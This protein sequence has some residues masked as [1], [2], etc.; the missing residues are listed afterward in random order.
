[1]SSGN[2]DKKSKKLL[3]MM[4]FALLLLNAGLFY[5]IFANKQEAEK[6]KVELV[7]T[8]AEVAELEYLTE[9]LRV[10]LEAKTGKNAQLDSIIRVRDTELQS[11]VRKVRN[12]LSRSNL[13]KSE[14]AKAKEELSGLRGQIEQLTAEIEQ[15]SK[16]NQFLKDENYAIQIQV[17]AEKEKVAEMVVVN[18]D[19]TKQVA[20]GSRIF[21][22]SLDVK[23]LRDVFFGDYKTTDKISK[24]DKIDVSFQL[25]NNDLAEKGSKII[26]FQVI[27]PTKSVLTNSNA[28]SGLAS[29]NGGEKQYTVKKSINFQNKNESGSFSIP[30]TEGMT[31]GQY[32]VN[33]FSDEHKMGSAEFT[34]K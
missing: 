28:G 8:Q 15:L 31:A 27:K 7:D 25:A 12:M 2:K 1:M 21:L 6:Q 33:V 17:E 30:K 34:L 13:T 23:P 3:F 24:L 9:E 10:N 22:K 14:L 26:Y 5:V 11:Q 18:T 20:V 4:I 29:F 32:T 16:E 19:L